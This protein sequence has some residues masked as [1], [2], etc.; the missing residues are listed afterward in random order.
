MTAVTDYGVQRIRYLILA[1]NGDVADV[2]R[3]PAYAGRPG[4]TG[5]LT[6]PPGC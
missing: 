4:A 1:G 6:A 2:G 5:A 3:I